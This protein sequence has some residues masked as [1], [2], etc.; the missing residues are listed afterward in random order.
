MNK[1]I[2]FIR[3]VSI[4]ALSDYAIWIVFDKYRIV[5]LANSFL[6]YVYQIIW[7]IGFIFTVLPAVL[8]SKFNFLEK[9]GFAILHNDEFQ[10]LTTKG[11]IF[12]YGSILILSFLI[13]HLINRK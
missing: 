4:L 12:F 8:L 1:F 5:L 11:V 7:A 3:I 13:T 6:N 10:Y 9:F 2:I